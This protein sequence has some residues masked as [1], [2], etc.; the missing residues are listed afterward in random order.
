MSSTSFT[1]GSQRQLR[2]GKCVIAVGKATRAKDTKIISTTNASGLPVA[3]HVESVS[4]HEVKLAEATIEI[5]LVAQLPER[6]IGS[7][8]Y[9]RDG[10]D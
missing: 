6:P 1:R 3:S 2:T 7:Y 8:A 5:S 9:D 4:P 10:L